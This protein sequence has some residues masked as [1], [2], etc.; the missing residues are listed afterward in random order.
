MNDHDQLFSRERLAGYDPERLSRAV[1][2]IVGCGAGGNN[3]AQSL[4]LV[5]VGELRFIDP[6]VVEPSNL[7][8]SPLFDAAQAGGKRRRYKAGECAARALKISRAEAPV[9]RFAAKRIEELGTGALLGSDA[10]VAAVDAF[11]VRAR[12]AYAARFLNIPLIEL[13][14]AGAHG[15]VSVW[16]G[17]SDKDDACW[18]CCHPAVEHGGVGCGL[19][20]RRAAAEGIVPSTQPLAGAIGNLAAVHVLEALHGR[21]PLGGRIA[22]LD[23]HRG[24]SR[25][26]QVARE[27]SCPGDHR[28]RMPV[29]TV[30]VSCTDTVRELM[31]AVR[32]F[33]AD[34]VLHLPDPYVE[35][36]PCQKCGTAV[37]IRRPAWALEAPPECH[38]CPDVPQFGAAGVVAVSSIEPDAMFSPFLLEWLGLGP[39]A[40][41]EVLD[42]ASELRMAVQLDGGVDD[43]YATLRREG[44]NGRRAAGREGSGATDAP[45]KE[46]RN[47]ETASATDQGHLPAPSRFA[48]VHRR[49][50]P[51]DDGA[52]GD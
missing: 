6:D 9:V 34:P 5:G 7:P 17:A 52:A 8:R 50:R 32:A 27:P 3:V 36:A 41:V 39:A 4:A 20:A 11:P 13:G 42:R 2:T 28:A 45:E 19:Y 14:F 21:F 44:R 15:H 47:G 51:G 10:V 18:S 25:I 35:E 48:R 24:T 43:L 33:A 16:P 37:R 31:E 26:V 40:V 22:H 23:L 38:A 49:D 29:R 12:L 30:P 46:T 1:V